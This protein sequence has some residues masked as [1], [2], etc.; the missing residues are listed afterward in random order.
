VMTFPSSTPARLPSRRSRVE[1]VKRT[2]KRK[3][4][5]AGVARQA[6]KAGIPVARYEVRLDGTIGVVVSKPSEATPPDNNDQQRV[7][8]GAAAMMRRPP[9]FIQG[10]IDRNGHARFYFRRTGFKRMAL[11]G[12]G[13]SMNAPAACARAMRDTA[14]SA[15]APA[16]RW[17]S[18]L[19]SGQLTAQ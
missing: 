2:R 8:W 10:F 12:K 18:V 3:P 1:P 13:C 9:K 16:A 17:S 6:A 4:T 14:C 19:V 11:P 15:A 5:L 7:G